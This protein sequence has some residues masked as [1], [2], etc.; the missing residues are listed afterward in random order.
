MRGVAQH[1]AFLVVADG[2][3]DHFLRDRAGT[4][5]RTSPSAPPAIRRGPRPR[6]AGRRPRPVRACAKA[7]CFA[8]VRM[9][10]L[11]ALGVEH[12]LG[13][14]ELR[15]DNRRSRRTVNALRRQEAVAARLVAG[16]DAVDRERHDVRL[17]GLRPEGGDDGMQ[18]PH[19]GRARPGSADAAPQRIDFGHGKVRMTTGRISP[20]TSIA[21]RPGF[22]ITAT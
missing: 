19:P 22:S 13:L 10:F 12:D 20:I 15:R 9:M 14:F 5:R 17:L 7:S 21:A 1:E 4:A 16:R 8:S 6:R 3:A 18:R 11:R 2:G